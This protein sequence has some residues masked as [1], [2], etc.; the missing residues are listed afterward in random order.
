VLQ[1]IV[2][3]SDANP[4]L[5]GQRSHWALDGVLKPLL[6]YRGIQLEQPISEHFCQ[7]FEKQGFIPGIFF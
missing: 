6:R 2:I 4:A 1:R 5:A 7:A 3:K